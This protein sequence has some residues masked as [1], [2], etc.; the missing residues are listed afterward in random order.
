MKYERFEEL[1]VWQGAKRTDAFLRKCQD[2]R[3]AGGD[4]HEG[5]EPS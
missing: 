4:S 2:I 1:P 5:D 3:D